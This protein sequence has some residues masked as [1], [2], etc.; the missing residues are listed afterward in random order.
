L[1]SASRRLA[2][3]LAVQVRHAH[4]VGINAAIRLRH[5]HARHQLQLDQARLRAHGRHAIKENIGG[6]RCVFQ[7]RRSVR[8][9]ILSENARQK[10][11][12]PRRP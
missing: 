5:Q 7:Q 9:H 12:T 4:H 1:L 8:F 11:A 10:M 3:A 6:G 2:A